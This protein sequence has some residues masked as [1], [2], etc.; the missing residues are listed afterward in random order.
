MGDVAG[1]SIENDLFT[2]EGLESTKTI[3]VTASYGNIS[4]SID[5]YLNK[6]DGLPQEPYILP[7][8]ILAN[9]VD[10]LETLILQMQGVI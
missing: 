7:E 8:Q 9:R 4:T 5:F 3:K 2:V 1:I 10:A 6:D